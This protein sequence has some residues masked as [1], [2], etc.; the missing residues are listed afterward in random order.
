MIG[1]LGD[2]EDE[3]IRELIRSCVDIDPE[4]RVRDFNSVRYKLRSSDQIEIEHAHRQRSGRITY[5]VLVGVLIAGILCTGLGIVQMKRDHAHRYDKI[6]EA[7]DRA[8]DEGDYVLS[9]EEARRAI[10]FDPDNEA[11][12][13]TKYKAETAKAYELAD[14]ETYEKIISES[15]ND[16]VDLPS[17]E[18]NIHAVTYIANAYYETDHFDKAIAK[19]ESLQEPEDDQLML[20][21]EALYK[22]GDM[23]KAKAALDR[24]TADVPQRFYL[25]GLIEE[26]TNYAAAVTSYEKVLT[27]RESAPGMSQIRRKALTQIVNLQIKNGDSEAAITRINSALK[28][29]PSLGNSPKVNI[30]L[31][32]CYYRGGH[33]SEAITQA[34][35]LIEKYNI[36]DAYAVKCSSQEKTGMYNDALATISEWEKTSPEDARPHIHRAMIYNSIAGKA[37]TDA[38]R[39]KTYPDFIKAYEEEHAWLEEHNALNA[40]FEVLD[41][42]YSEAVSILRQ[43]EEEQ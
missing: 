11:G 33:Y 38:E 34:S 39:M 42:P 9:E 13:I 30:M 35:A 40:D 36:T 26:E 1:D 25:Q 29:D 28:E 3:G 23:A 2:I 19:L 12:Y 16:I 20:L 15:D 18:D 6:I 24:M 10:E 31:M 4:K 41:G 17:L 14:D 27:I 8:Y 21:G 22:A 32:D 7:A 37:N 43:M 5:I